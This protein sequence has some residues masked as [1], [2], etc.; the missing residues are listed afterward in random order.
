MHIWGNSAIRVEPS[1]WNQDCFA[2]KVRLFVSRG[3]D[4]I[5]REGHTAHRM[6]DVSYFDEL[7]N[8]LW[9]ILF[10]QHTK[11]FALASLRMLLGHFSDNLANFF[12]FNVDYLFHKCGEIIF[13]AMVNIIVPVVSILF[14]FSKFSWIDSSEVSHKDVKAKILSHVSKA[15]VPPMHDPSLSVV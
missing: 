11:M 9:K 10:R 4:H 15:V 12:G 2:Q 14:P 1:W 3:I 7:T 8:F 13:C 5:H 6:A